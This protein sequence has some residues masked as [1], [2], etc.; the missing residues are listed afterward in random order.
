MSEGLKG[1]V[2]CRNDGHRFKVGK[3]LE[4]CDSKSGPLRRISTGAKFI[5]HDKA[6]RKQVVQKLFNSC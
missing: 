5:Q 2:M 1:I 3:M 4:N 6:T